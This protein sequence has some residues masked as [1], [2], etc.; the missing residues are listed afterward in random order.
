[1]GNGFTYV[2]GPEEHTK[3]EEYDET[4]TGDRMCP[5]RAYLKKEGFAGAARPAHKSF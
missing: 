5:G 4:I 1:M 2:S 3:E